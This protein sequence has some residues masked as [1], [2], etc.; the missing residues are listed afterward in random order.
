MTRE[1]LK[2]HVHELIAA[3]DW[4][5]LRDSVRDWV[6]PEIADV[7]LELEKHERA[8]L[9]RMLPREL[10]VEVFAHLEFDEQNALLLDLTDEETR[11][12]L[13]DMTPDDRT[14]LLEE[15]P[16]QATQRLLSLLAP[17]DLKEARWLLGYPEDTVGRLMTPDYI[18]VQPG[19][20]I[21]EA[22]HHIRRYGQ[23]SETAN[24]IYVT[25]AQWRLLDDIELRR[26]ILAQPDASVETI[27]DH[28]FPSISAFA[29]RAE[30]VAVFRRYD[31]VALPVIASDGVL[32]GIVTVDDVLDVAEEEATE[33]FHKVGSVEPIHTSLRDATVGFLYRRRIVWLLALVFVNVFSGAALQGFEETLQASIALVFF[34]PL[35]IAGGGNAGS[36]SATLVIRALATGDVHAGDWAWLLGRELALALIIGATMALGVAL[37]SAWRAPEVM[38]V[39]SLAMTSIVLVGSTIG[40]VLPFAFSRL[41][42]D[43]A[44]ASAPL[45]TSLADI[46]GVIIYLALATWLLG[47]GG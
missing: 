40:I 8:L 5:A 12:L 21:D 2:P 26:F 29:D 1:Q 17:D 30:A 10:A 22:L 31:L 11:R 44:T 23:D 47:G 6:A 43:P 9:W 28:T 27:M 41:G 36:Q 3:R 7:M 34:L 4:S 13:A 20:T 16:G 46:T 38:L 18:A 33:S 35:L 25:D 42:I 39:V 45:V 32:L 15:L 19:W 14:H 24:M 37:V